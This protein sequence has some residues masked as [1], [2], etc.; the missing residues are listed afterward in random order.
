MVISCTA[1]TYNGVYAIPSS[2]P[3]NIKV[4]PLVYVVVS[5]QHGISCSHILQML[6]CTKVLCSHSHPPIPHFN[7]NST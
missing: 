1:W 5:N 2:K 3:S 7:D 6:V 4:I